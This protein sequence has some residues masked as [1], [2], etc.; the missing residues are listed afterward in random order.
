MSINH[1]TAR[2]PMRDA[3]HE[4]THHIP[5]V[6]EHRELPGGHQGMALH[7]RSWQNSD[8]ASASTGRPAQKRDR[9]HHGHHDRKPPRVLVAW[10]NR[11]AAFFG[12]GPVEQ[13]HR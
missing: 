7:G 6:P 1:H 3:L 2:H 8:A 9:R 10:Q 4:A 5:G 12:Q 11:I 13:E